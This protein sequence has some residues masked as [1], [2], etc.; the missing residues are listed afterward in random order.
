MDGWD[1]TPALKNP[2]VGGLTSDRDLKEYHARKRFEIHRIHRT[3][4]AS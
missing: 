3:R 2:Y 1:E 4:F